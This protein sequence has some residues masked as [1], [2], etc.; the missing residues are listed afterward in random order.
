MPDQAYDFFEV[1]DYLHLL[2]V[3]WTLHFFQI[4]DEE[5]RY[6]KSQKGCNNKW[7]QLSW[8]THLFVQSLR[9]VIV[10]GENF[11]KRDLNMLLKVNFFLF[12]FLQAYFN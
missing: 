1:R 10:D 9:F 5:R 3:H 4:N 7:R 8:I 11:V 6:F 12:F 2:A